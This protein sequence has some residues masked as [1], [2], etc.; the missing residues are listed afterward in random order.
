MG[1]GKSFLGEQAAQ[2]ISLPFWDLD[3][4]IEEQTGQSVQDLF[5]SRGEAA[6]RKEERAALHTL[7]EQ[8]QTGLVATGG[9]TPCFFDNLDCMK[10]NGVTIYLQTDPAILAKRLLPLRATRPLLQAYQTENELL[11][12]LEAMIRERVAWYLQADVIFTVPEDPEE[13][14]DHLH[15]FILQISGH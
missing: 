9:G 6:F 15:R 13:A 1:S 12:Y 10:K 3:Q 4:F 8:Q 7:I 2:R 5:A 14:L 11:S